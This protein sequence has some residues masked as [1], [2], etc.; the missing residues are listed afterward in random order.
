[1]INPFNQLY[2]LDFLNFI[3]FSLA[4]E[5]RLHF[6]TLSFVLFNDK[7]K[8]DFLSKNIFLGFVASN[9]VESFLVK[10]LSRNMRIK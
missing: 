1:L 6:I 3:F 5:K 7:E 8:L 9:G 10:L 4:Q 2:H